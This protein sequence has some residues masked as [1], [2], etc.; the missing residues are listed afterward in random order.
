M[1][2][3]YLTRREA[4]PSPPSSLRVSAPERPA[5]APAGAASTSGAAGA[6]SPA[7]PPAASMATT[8]IVAR[9]G[10]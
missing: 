1:A 10:T 5:G 9:A 3:F 6:R 7:P 4:G 2:E 8:A